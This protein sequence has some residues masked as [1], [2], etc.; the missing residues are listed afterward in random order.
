MYFRAFIG[1]VVLAPFPL[2]QSVIAQT[3]VAIVEEV[4]SKTAGLELMDY[5]TVGRT[6]RLAAEE[7]LVIGYLKSCWRETIV[8]GAV[9]IGVEQS[10]VKDGRVQRAKVR[11]DA[12]ESTPSKETAASGAMVF[13]NVR[14]PLPKKTIYALSPIFELKGAGHL[15]IERL[16]QREKSINVDTTVRQRGSF[17]DLS[18]MHFSLVAGGLYR[19]R[20]GRNEVIFKIDQLADPKSV[21]I[22]GR[23][24]HLGPP[25]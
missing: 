7:K 20:L 16:D 12:G 18:K 19:A 6:I 21:D 25:D 15:I 2:S 4:D 1:A 3:P 23:L 10:E 22:I 13:R 17:V 8:G 14:Q 11:C 9:T 24:V 5:L